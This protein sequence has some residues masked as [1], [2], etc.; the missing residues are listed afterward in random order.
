VRVLR[1]VAVRGHKGVW[2]YGWVGGWVR[3]LCLWVCVCVNAKNSFKEMRTLLCVESEGYV[4]YVVAGW[5]QKACAYLKSIVY[6]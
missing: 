6:I 1:D 5:L 2:L 3:G 4:W